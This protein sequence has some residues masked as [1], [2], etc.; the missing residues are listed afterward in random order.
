MNAMIT[1]RSN[2]CIP[3]ER[4]N[5]LLIF[6]WDSSKTCFIVN[7]NKDSEQGLEGPSLSSCYKL[8]VVSF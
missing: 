4:I 5:G 8:N 3:K 7:Q 6:Y 2:L 1:A